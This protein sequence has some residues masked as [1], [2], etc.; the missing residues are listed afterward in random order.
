MLIEKTP[1]VK[2]ISIAINLLF[3]FN[4]FFSYELIILL[5]MFLWYNFVENRKLEMVST[6]KMFVKNKKI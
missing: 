6:E 5:I 1:Q 2:S 4:F 3:F